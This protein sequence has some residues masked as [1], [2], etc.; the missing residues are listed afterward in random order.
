MSE[1]VTI[2]TDGACSGNPGPGGWGAILL[3]KQSARFIS[4]FSP[5]TTNNRMELAAAIGALKALNKDSVE[6]EIHTD[7][8]Y[9]KNGIQEWLPSWRSRGW[10][11]FDKKPVKNKEYWEELDEQVKL[12]HV[13]WRWVKGHGL[14]R[15]NNFVDWLA[16][17]AIKHRAGRNERGSINE[18]ENFIDRAITNERSL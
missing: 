11:T 12:H 15:Y 14:S 2:Y 4:G 8:N 7:S 17:D 6:L 3:Y 16:R 9:V 5:H 10:K 1:R 13:H 18:I